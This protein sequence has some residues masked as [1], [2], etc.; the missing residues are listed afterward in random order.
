MKIFPGLFIIIVIGMVFFCGCTQVT[1]T[2]NSTTDGATI[3]VPMIPTTSEA[4]IVSTKIPDNVPPQYP[5]VVSADGVKIT[6]HSAMKNTKIKS[7]NSF[8]GNIL[9]VMNMT[10][11]NLREQ[12]PLVINEKTITITNGGPVHDP[13]YKDLANPF[14]WGSIPP[15]GEKTGEIV[16]STNISTEKFNITLKNEDGDKLINRYIG[17]IPAGIYAGQGQVDGQIPDTGIE[18]TTKPVNTGKVDLTLNSALKTTKIKDSNPLRGNIFVVVNM[19][20][21]NLQEKEA[22]VANE[23]T[24]DINGG[25]PMTQKI[26]DR[27]SNPFYWGTI[28]PEGSRTGEVVF[29]V[30]EDTGSFTITLLDEK[31]NTLLS[32]PVGTINEGPYTPSLDNPALLKSSD[33]DSVV[34]SLNSAQKAS[35]YTDARFT[36]VYHDGCRSYSPEEFFRLGNGDCKDYA[37]FLSYV[38]AQHG[39]DA[40]IVSFKYSVDGT[41][42]GHVVTLFTDKDGTMYYMTTPDVSIM[43]SVTSVDN[44]LQKECARL[45]VPSIAN[46]TVNQAGTQDTCVI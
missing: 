11:E 9:V 41:R 4:S 17:I 42:K 10:I 15:K 8:K 5:V 21:N 12:D 40:K 22:F 32:K 16:F 31:G 7:M 36:F 23:N 34:K 44:L 28:P 20:I 14:Y 13:V 30:K 38:L 35:E 24:V 26:Y 25:G 29:G 6:I 45:R 27:L 19:T 2:G 39:Y 18:D 3:T 1:R 33:F 37:T 46:Y 43:R